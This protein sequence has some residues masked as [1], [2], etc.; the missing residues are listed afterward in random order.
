MLHLPQVTLCCVDGI[1]HALALRAL[2]RHQAEIRF[3][4]T[5]LITDAVPPGVAVP[6][7]IDVASVGPIRS[8]EAYSQLVM[9]G[10]VKHIATSH[11]LLIQW[12]GYVAHPARWKPDFLD[13]DYIGAVWPDAPKGLNVGN[14]GFSLRS[15]KLLATLQDDRFP[16]LTYNEDTTICSLHRPR[17]ESDFAIRFAS[18]DLARQFSFELDSS[19]VLAGAETFG[20]HGV[21]NLFLVENEPEIVAMAARFSDAIARSEALD[22]LFRRLAHHER[23]DAALAVGQRILASTE[24]ERVATGL[25]RAREEVVRRRAA[26]PRRRLGSGLLKRLRLARERA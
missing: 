12:D 10:L 25:V 2:T 4:R 22:I 17:L 15:H 14:G 13:V 5:L 26:A 1:N 7:G 9:K 8:Q 23:W 24:N 3:A 20:F 19:Y 11:V 16:L 6:K 18:E 21:F